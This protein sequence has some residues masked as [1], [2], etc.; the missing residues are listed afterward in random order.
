MKNK[1]I[2]VAIFAV[3]VILLIA[4]IAIYNYY[5]KKKGIYPVSSISEDVR[6]RTIYYRDFVRREENGKIMMD[7]DKAK[8]SLKIPQGWETFETSFSAISIKT[9]DFIPLNNDVSKIPF[10]SVGCWINFDVQIDK[11]EDGYQNFTQSILDSPEYFAE[12]DGSEQNIKIGNLSAL[13]NISEQNSEK[14]N[15]KG[16]FV[17]I[18]KGNFTY[19][20][21]SFL[22]GK[23][24][25]MCEREFDD[26]LNSLVIK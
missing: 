16:I 17:K 10:P 25:E 22:F 15:G 9:K 20:I 19:K 14:I 2:F 21:E 1:V 5:D 18:P 4:G 3:V 11:Q 12:G 23:D 6:S 7:S 26:F 13:K 24:R 8:V